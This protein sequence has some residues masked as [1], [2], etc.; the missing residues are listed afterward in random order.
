MTDA[1]Y[2]EHF[3]KVVEENDCVVQQFFNLDE[4]C[5]F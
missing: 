4:T 1:K 5:L 2:P 3:K